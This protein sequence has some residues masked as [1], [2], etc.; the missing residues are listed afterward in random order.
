MQHGFG[1]PDLGVDD[2]NQNMDVRVMGAGYLN[3]GGYNTKGE[4]IKRK[5]KVTEKRSSKEK[6]YFNRVR[7][8]EKKS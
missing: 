1:N 5:E 7:I 3:G 6:S 8:R 4:N 2:R